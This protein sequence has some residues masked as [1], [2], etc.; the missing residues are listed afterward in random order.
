MTTNLIDTDQALADLLKELTTL[1]SAT[2][3]LD[4][5]GHMASDA[6]DAARRV[7]ALSDQ[8]MQNSTE[9]LNMSAE[10]AALTQ[11]RMAKV[12]AEQK[13]FGERMTAVMQARLDEI[14]TEQKSFGERMTITTKDR[15]DEISAEQKSFSERMTDVTQGRLDKISEE[16]ESFAEDMQRYIQSELQP[17]LAKFQRTANINRWLLIA[18]LLLLAWSILGS[19]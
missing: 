14:S 15:F 5:A 2:Q 10:Q 16:Q 1:K 13:S 12:I 17:Q 18:T 3:Q 11:E 6:I 4:T 8:I 7:T 9:Q 19:S